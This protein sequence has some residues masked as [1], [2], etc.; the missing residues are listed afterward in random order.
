MNEPQLNASYWE[1]R[2]QDEQ[3]PWD[4]GYASP[5][6]LHYLEGIAGKGTRILIPGAGRAYEAVWLHRQGFQEVW[7]CDW[8][9]SAFGLLREQAPDFPERHLLVQDFFSLELEVDLL[10]EQTFFCAIPPAQRPDYARQAARLVVPE[11]RVA[12]LLFAQPFPQQ[13]PPFGGTAEEYQAVFSP[14]FHILR[15]ETAAH[16]IAP[17]AQ[18]E[19]FF[20]LRKK[21]D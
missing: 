3:T 7:V 11:G 20:E 9:A 19:L 1:Q 12:G 15:M 13:G 8:A 4:I 17:R 21:P 16:S 10:L 6:L 5:P 18:R 14:Y 2:Y